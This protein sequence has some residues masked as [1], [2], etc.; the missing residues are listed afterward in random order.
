MSIPTS[1]YQTVRHNPL[2][3]CYYR[4]NEKTGTKAYDFG[5]RHGLDG[6][7]DGSPSPAGHG[8]LIQADST[9]GSAQFGSSGQ[10]VEIPDAAP[11]RITGDITLEAWIVIYTENQTASIIGKMNSASNNANPYY[12]SLA[13]GKGHLQVGAG[14][15]KVSNIFSK[16]LSIGCPYHI[17]GTLFRKNLYLYINGVEEGMVSIG[18]Q[19]L[20]DV[21]EPVMIGALKSNLY[22][23]SGLISEVAIYNGAL[24]PKT[25]ERHFNIGR[26]IVPNIS[27]VTTFDPPSYS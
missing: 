4:L 2:L 19:I 15:E 25:I 1:Y 3:A 12:L 26:Q 23:F 14:F 17:V 27:H 13:E 9:A 7:Y 24:S 11:L 16:T 20:E 6:F 22:R 8:A 10:N 5:A 21:E 18:S